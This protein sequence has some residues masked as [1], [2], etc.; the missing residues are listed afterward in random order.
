M[1]EGKVELAVGVGPILEAGETAE[2]VI[3]AIRQINPE[4]LVQDRGSYLRVMAPRRCEVTREAIEKVLGRPFLLPGD[5][6]G[7]M[8]SFM[9]S[10]T[11]TE[12]RAV[13]TLG[14]P[15]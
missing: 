8:P 11:V 9:G 13:W 7:L 6:E 14:A 2:A 10:F 12:E 4:V 15:P 3:T 1:S 5:L